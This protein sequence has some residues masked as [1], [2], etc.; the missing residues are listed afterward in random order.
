MTCFGLS[1]LS[2]V[3]LRGRPPTLSRRFQEGGKRDF[4]ESRRFFDRALPVTRDDNGEERH[5]NTPEGLP[6]LCQADR[7]ISHLRSLAKSTFAPCVRRE[8]GGGF[9]DLRD[10]SNEDPG[11]R[12][13]TR[14]GT[15]ALTARQS[16]SGG[17]ESVARQLL[18]PRWHGAHRTSR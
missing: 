17:E 16:R 3:A 12:R 1:E 9:R 11:D 4:R 2:G 13:R 14:A 8:T 18:L 10:Q 5:R 7:C 6:R 15:A